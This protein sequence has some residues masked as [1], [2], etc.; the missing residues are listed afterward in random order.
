MSPLDD[1]SMHPFVGFC[2]NTRKINISMHIFE[3]FSWKKITRFEPR[4]QAA[5]VEKAL[6]RRKIKKK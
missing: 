3:V 2:I 5:Q 1:T 4:K 6:R